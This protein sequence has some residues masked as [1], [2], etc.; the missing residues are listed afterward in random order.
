MRKLALVALVLLVAIPL[1]AHA[2]S[3]D[4]FVLRLGEVTYMNGKGMSGEAL[5]RLQ[6]SNGPR[7][8]WFKRGGH[9]YV[10][11]AGQEIERAEAIIAPE[12][13]LGRKQ[14]ALGQKQASLGGEQ[15]GLGARQATLGGRQAAAAGDDHRQSELSRQQETLS[16]QQEELSKRQE[17]LSR[18]QGKL[19]DEQERVSA[20][21]EAQL[22]A[23]ADQCIRSGVAKELGR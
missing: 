6:A 3:E 22:A 21:I 1:V 10:V 9:T 17:V 15:A 23:L 12:T 14:A 18:E 19:S 8:F 2:P 4:S 13:E 16:K 11:K 20:Q 7:F 5:K